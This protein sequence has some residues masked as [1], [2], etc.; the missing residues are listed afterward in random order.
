MA[1]ANAGI[2]VLLKEVTQD[3]IA[4]GELERR[5]GNP[6]PIVEPRPSVGTARR[7]VCLVE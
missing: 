4:G 3:G 6:Q 7:T 5:L 2:P 1:Y